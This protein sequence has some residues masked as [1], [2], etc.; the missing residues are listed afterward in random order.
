MGN[1]W[2]NQVVAVLTQAGID[3][4]EDHPTEALHWQTKSRAVVALTGLDTQAGLAQITVSFFSPRQMGG[5]ACQTGAAGAAAA[6]AEGGYPCKMGE[7]SYA[8]G[9]DCYEIPIALNMVVY[10]TSEDGETP[11]SPASSWNVTIDGVNVEWVKTCKV[12]Q[13]R[14]RR[15]VWDHKEATPIGISDGY[16][17]WQVELIQELPSGI[18]GQSMPDDPFT[19]VITHGETS[20]TYTGCRWNEVQRNHSAAGIT[21]RWQG[22][23]LEKA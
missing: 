21:L 6:L 15:L 16:G 12:W 20:E 9:C 17:G 1:E 3:A 5:W 14:Q 2:L 13:D 4:G 10:Q 7:M 18:A 22:F 19:L 11:V 23:G 8:S